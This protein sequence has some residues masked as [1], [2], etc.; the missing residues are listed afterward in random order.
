MKKYVV[1]LMALFMLT[2]AVNGK[3]KEEALT[4]N[5]QLEGAGMTSQNAVQVKVT[6]ITKNKNKVTD[7]DLEKAAVHGVLFRDYDDV[8]N[9][10]FG[11]VASHKAL[12]GDIAAEAQ[13]NDFFE[14]FFKNGDYKNYVQLVGDS[15]RVVKAGKEWKISAIVRVNNH[16]LRSMLKKQGMAKD[17]GGGW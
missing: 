5:Y 13:Y 12:M 11:T 17:L 1:F 8:T 3:T 7:A 15:R 6:I 16:Q 10:G 14:P 4:T 9:S 2:P